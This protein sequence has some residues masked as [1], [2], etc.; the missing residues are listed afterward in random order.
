MTLPTSASRLP[1]ALSA[2]HT[3]ARSHLRPPPVF[4]PL[5]GH[6]APRLGT[7]ATWRRFRAEAMKAQREKEQTEVAVVEESF[8]VRET[9]PLDGADDLME[10]TDDSWVV[11]LEQSVNIF[12]TRS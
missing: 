6:R 8:P 4:L 9:A 7:A 10:P 3:A 11:K 2:E 5:H 1:A 12:L